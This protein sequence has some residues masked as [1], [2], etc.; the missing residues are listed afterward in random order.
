MT[1]R[2]ILESARVRIPV[3]SYETHHSVKGEIPAWLSHKLPLFGVEEGDEH[4]LNSGGRGIL[5]ENGGEVYRIKGTDPRGTIVRKVSASDKNMIR[6]IDQSVK[7]APDPQDADLVLHST[8]YV[9]FYSYQNGKPWNFLTETNVE[10]SRRAFCALEEAYRKQGFKAPC[11]FA[12]VIEYPKI[13]W[14][15]RPLYSIVFHLPDAESDLREDEFEVQ[16]RRHLQHASVEELMELKDGVCKLFGILSKW[17]AFECGA[18]MDA[19][20]V[21][22]PNSFL[23]QNYVVAHV[24]ERQVGVSRVDHTSTVHSTNEEDIKRAAYKFAPALFNIP[25]WIIQA[26]EMAKKGVKYDTKR[27]SNYFD[28]AFKFHEDMSDIEYPETVGY[29][30][31]CFDRFDRDLGLPHPEP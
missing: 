5:V 22:S 7:K 15:N 16:M 23:G 10:N 20:L 28:A 26:L 27:Y 12:A 30:S 19:G 31:Q 4:Y 6:D 25:L 11:R 18:L 13:L 1:Y 9:S 24:A 14:Q 21:P 8:L 3:K 17:H 2:Y 29:A